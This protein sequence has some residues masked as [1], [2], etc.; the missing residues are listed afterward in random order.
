M[1][2][3][4]TNK[5]QDQLFSQTPTQLNPG[6]ARPQDFQ[7]N[8]DRGTGQTGDT[9][10]ERAALLAEADSDQKSKLTGGIPVRNKIP[11]NRHRND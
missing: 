8:T 9:K 4:P 2:N 7:V 11:H 6:A 5:E 3:A 1:S 10:A